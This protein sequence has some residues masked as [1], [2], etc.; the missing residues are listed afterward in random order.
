MGLSKRSHLSI[1]IVSPLP[2]RVRPFPASSELPPPRSASTK[3][4]R[5]PQPTPAARMTYYG[6]AEAASTRCFA[7]GSPRRGEG[8]TGA[9]PGAPL[10]APRRP[11][12]AGLG[13]GA[14]PGAGPDS[15]RQLLPGHG[16]ALRVAPAL[17]LRLPL[18]GARLL[19]L[20]RR[21]PP[22]PPGS[23]RPVR[24]AALPG[25]KRPER[26]GRLGLGL[27]RTQLLAGREKKGRAGRRLW[28]RPY[29]GTAPARPDG[30]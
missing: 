16:P 18:G 24:E 6:L 23:A 21:L 7:T 22:L 17:P 25:E 2:A 19:V 1:S 28:Q 13:P 5:G 29:S 8:P 20:H 14:G 12:R 3:T 15:L 26:G 27:R 11:P 4:K 9:A 30:C 10:P